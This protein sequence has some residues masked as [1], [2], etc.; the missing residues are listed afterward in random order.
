MRESVRLLRERSSARHRWKSPALPLTTKSA[1][2][3]L[4]PIRHGSRSRRRRTITHLLASECYLGD[5]S[6]SNRPWNMSRLGYAC[7]TGGQRYAERVAPRPPIV[8]AGSGGVSRA[9]NGALDQLRRLQYELFLPCF[10]RSL[11]AKVSCVSHFPKSAIAESRLAH[12]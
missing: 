7:Q 9:G 3:A 12:S 4:S 2:K 10:A 1:L 5:A 8:A 6:A 11:A